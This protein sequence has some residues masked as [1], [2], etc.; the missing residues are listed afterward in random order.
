MVH[1][2]QRTQTKVKTTNRM[3]R[4]QNLK[5]DEQDSTENEP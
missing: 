2:S 4:L 5:Q 3:K 1:F